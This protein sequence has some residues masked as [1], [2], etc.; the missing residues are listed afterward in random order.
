MTDR[1]GLVMANVC[2]LPVYS[3]SH[4]IGLS[5]MLPDVVLVLILDT[6]ALGAECK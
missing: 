1:I 2:G 4:M 5:C 3:I 6:Y